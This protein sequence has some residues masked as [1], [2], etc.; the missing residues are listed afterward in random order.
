MNDWER[1]W[2]FWM[3]AMV[4]GSAILGVILWIL[5]SWLFGHLHVSLH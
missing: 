5:G 1:M 2:R 4:T 3:A